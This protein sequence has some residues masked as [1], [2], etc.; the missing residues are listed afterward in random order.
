MKF[1]RT[2]R[3]LD[4]S[5]THD[6]NQVNPPDEPQFEGVVFS[7]GSV[8]LRWLTACRSTSVWSCLED[9]MKIHGHPEYGTRIEW[10]DPQ[11]IVAKAVSK[12]LAEQ[13]QK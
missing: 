12:A 9:A 2:Y 11:V 8:A 6:A 5:A 3:A 7:D 4:I 13:A 10:F 1:F